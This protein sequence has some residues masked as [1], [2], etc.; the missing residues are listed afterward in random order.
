VDPD[1]K[2][3]PLTCKVNGMALAIVEGGESEEIMGTGFVVVAG[4]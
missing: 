3:T 4:P 1:R 2:F